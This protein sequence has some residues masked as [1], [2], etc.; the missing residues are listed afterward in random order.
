MCPSSP[1]RR[2]RRPNSY[3]EKLVFLFAQKFFPAMKHVTGARKH[4]GKR[5]IFN[6]LGPL[7][8]PARPDSQLIAVFREEVMPT[9]SRPSEILGIPN[10]MLVASHDGLDEISVSAGTVCFPSRVRQF[11]RF[12]FDPK[13]CA[14]SADVAAIKGHTARTNARIMKETLLGRHPELVDT[15]A[16]ERRLSRSWPQT[17]RTGRGCVRLPPRQGGDQKRQGVRE[18]GGARLMIVRDTEDKGA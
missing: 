13:D 5:T 4:I 2:G 10:V 1:R 3:G 17:S 7:C 11:R 14:L 15:V 16:I 8:N 6:L 9:Y 18:A 12:E